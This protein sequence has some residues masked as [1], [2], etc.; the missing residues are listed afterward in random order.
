MLWATQGY[1]VYTLGYTVRMRGYERIATLQLGC[2]RGTI[3]EVQ[4][5]P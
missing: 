5:K 3:L 4:A 2:V 1:R